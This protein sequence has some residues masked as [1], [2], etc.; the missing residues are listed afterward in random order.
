MSWHLGLCGTK[1]G[2]YR[3][4]ICKIGQTSSRHSVFIGSAGTEGSGNSGAVMFVEEWLFTAGSRHKRPNAASD[5]GSADGTVTQTG[6]AIATD[7]QVP[8]GD[9]NDGHQLVHAHFTGPLFLQLPEQLL[10]TGIL[11]C[12]ENRRAC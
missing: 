10:R 11:H 7:H 3:K 1:T 12:R 5:D 8:T 9:E 6:G 4:F 2:Y